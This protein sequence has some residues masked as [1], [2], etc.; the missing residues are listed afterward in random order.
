MVSASVA[1]PAALVTVALVDGAF[2]G[3]RT[4]TGRNGRIRKRAYYTMAM[5]RGLAVGAAQLGVV[6][7]VMAVALAASPDRYASFLRA[8]TAMLWVIG[9]YAAAV[10]ASLL[11][12][13]VSPRRPATLLMVLGLGPLTL[14]RPWVAAVGGAAAVWAGTDALTAGCAGL[15]TAGVLAVE[16]FLHRRWYAQPV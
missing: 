9:P 16:P 10:L 14:M 7:V 2:A 12:Y 3:F 5:V 8:G 4:A 6:G 13:L 11:G 1:V 15:A